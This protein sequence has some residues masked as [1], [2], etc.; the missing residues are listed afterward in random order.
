MSLV[1]PG[2]ATRQPAVVDFRRMVSA[3][4]A[5]ALALSPQGRLHVEAAEADGLTAAAR[6]AI[7]AAFARGEGHGLL[8]LG[9]VELPAGLGDSLAY[10]RDLGRL[11]LGRLCAVPDLEEQR[12][13]VAVAA[14]Q[15]ELT[16]LATAA[17]P[18]TGGEY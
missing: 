10:F 8:H 3:P 12:T 9:A 16:R 7:V 1:S 14:P 18:M 5:L 15:E 11:F 17:P 4:S 2:R 6:A 13:R